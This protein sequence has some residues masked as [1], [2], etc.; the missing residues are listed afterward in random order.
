MHDMTGGSQPSLL[1]KNSK[2]KQKSNDFWDDENARSAFFA[3]LK[4]KLNFFVL[5]YAFIFRLF[6]CDFEEKFKWEIVHRSVSDLIDSFSRV[7]ALC[8]SITAKRGKS[9]QEYEIRSNLYLNEKSLIFTCEIIPRKSIANNKFPLMM[10]KQRNSKISIW[11]S[12][13]SLP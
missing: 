6:S 13:C 12:S 5:F 10:I 7:N 4:I 8:A 9:K 1:S 11:N 2:P 3:D